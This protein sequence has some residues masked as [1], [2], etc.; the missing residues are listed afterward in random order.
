M[1]GMAT[2]IGLYREA[3]VNYRYFDHISHSFINF[4]VEYFVSLVVLIHWV[5]ISLKFVPT[6]P[7]NNKSIMV[8]IMVWWPIS[9]KPLFEPTMDYSTNI[10]IYIFIYI[11]T[12]HFASMIWTCIVAYD[13]G[14]SSSSLLFCLNSFCEYLRYVV[15]KRRCRAPFI[16]WSQ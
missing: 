16:D 8:Q 1:S 6:S 11:Y 10:Y 7:I 12:H 14:Q 4:H 15:D 2:I 13:P 3:E 5:Q 9:S